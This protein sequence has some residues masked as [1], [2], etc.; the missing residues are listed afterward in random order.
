MLVRK[1]EAYK[2]AVERR[3]KNIGEVGDS[4][5]A[6]SKENIFMT[7]GICTR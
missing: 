4:T 2:V 6:S 7:R 3:T 5:R 1:A